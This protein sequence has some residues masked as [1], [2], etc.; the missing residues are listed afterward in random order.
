[1]KYIDSNHSYINE[2]GESY[3]SVTSLIKK[4]EPVKDWQEIAEKYA[5]KHKREVEEVQASWKE[6]GRKS[7]EKG[8]AYHSRME[9]EYVSKGSID[10]NGKLYKVIPT[11]TEDGVKFAIPLKL[12]DGIYP[13][14]IVYSDKY[15]VSGQADLVEIRDGVIYMKDYKTSKEIR[16]E[17]HKHWKY[18]YEMMLT[19][20]NHI[21]NC[22]FYQYALQLN[23]YMYLLKTH[24][25]KLTIGTMEIYHVKDDQTIH[26]EVPNL[27]KE[28]KSLLDYHYEILKYSF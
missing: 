1:M 16:K 25:R 22:N 10:I 23:I 11:P 24:N 13:E 2:K 19:P 15:K 8:I 18:G 7:I 27:Q 14:I 5:K 20:L 6:E 21:M 12:E 26:Y 17:S 28:A 9:E 3:L 4:Y